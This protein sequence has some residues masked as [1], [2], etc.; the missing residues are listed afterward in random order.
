VAK[1]ASNISQQYQRKSSQHLEKISIIEN[2]ENI[3]ENQ[4]AKRRKQA[5][6]IAKAIESVINNGVMAS[7]GEIIKNSR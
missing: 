6:N 4:L 5:E 2:G 7:A 3:N 1:K